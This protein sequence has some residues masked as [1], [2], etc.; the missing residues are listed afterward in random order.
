MLKIMADKMGADVSQ[1]PDIEVLE[2][3]TRPGMLAE[4]IDQAAE[5][6]KPGSSS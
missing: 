1:D 6:S 5:S 4:Q 3:A 2:E